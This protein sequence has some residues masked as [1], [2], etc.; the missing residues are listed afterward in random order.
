VVLEPL[1]P[2]ERARHERGI[3]RI[4]R[5]L[6]RRY[7]P[8][9]YFI[10]PNSER[11]I[12]A[13]AES[14]WNAACGSYRVLR[15]GGLTY[16]VDCLDQAGLCKFS[17]SHV[18]ADRFHFWLTAARDHTVCSITVPFGELDE[19]AHTRVCSYRR[20]NCAPEYGGRTS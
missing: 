9:D 13:S 3:E 2:E 1:T 17:V 18:D 11:V 19:A 8:S 4:R 10:I 6:F 7:Q 14:C 12:P 16:V 5:R 15:F 20:T